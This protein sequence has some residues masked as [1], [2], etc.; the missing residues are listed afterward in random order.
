MPENVF[1]YRRQKAAIKN[2]LIIMSVAPV[3]R[4]HH[5]VRLLEVVKRNQHR[6]LAQYNSLIAD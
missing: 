1:I 5:H 3:H 2:G 4:H 6:A